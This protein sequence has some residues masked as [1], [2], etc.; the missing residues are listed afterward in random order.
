MHAGQEQIEVEAKPQESVFLERKESLPAPE[1]RA[2]HNIG[3][4][5]G[6][7]VMKV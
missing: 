2:Q 7:G 3:T 4:L 6:F 5:R 1:E